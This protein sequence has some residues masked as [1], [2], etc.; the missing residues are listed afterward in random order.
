MADAMI[1]AVFPARCH[2]RLLCVSSSISL[3]ENIMQTQ[4]KHARTVL[5]N[6]MEISAQFAQERSE[7]QRR[8]ELVRADFDV[9]KDAGF[10]LTPVSRDCGGLYEHVARSTRPLCEMLR[11][12]AHGDSSVALVAAMHPTVIA[13]GGWRDI[14][15]APAPFTKAW[16][17]QRRWVFQTACDGHWWGTIVSEPGTGG[18]TAKTQAVA[19]R[20]PTGR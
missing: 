13:A 4:A 6:I 17:E 7:R 11:S 15:T 16:D 12:L 20:A 9:L 2:D 1:E 10:L 18:D 14:V 3:W 8:R 5:A 19:R